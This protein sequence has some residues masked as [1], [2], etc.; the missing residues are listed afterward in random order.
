MKKI[1]LIFFLLIFHPCLFAQD[2]SDF[3]IEGV[4]IGDSLLNY[5]SLSKIQSAEAK[6]Q[7]AND[8]YLIYKFECGSSFVKALNLTAPK[9][10]I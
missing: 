2:I 4:S 6:F 5:A 3:Q 9:L 10:R 7:Y 8:K 1:F